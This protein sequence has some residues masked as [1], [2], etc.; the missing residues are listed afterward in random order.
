MDV[1]DSDDDAP[2]PR[3]SMSLEVREEILESQ[4]MEIE[5]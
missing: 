4:R 5:Q 3:H 2:P 1:S